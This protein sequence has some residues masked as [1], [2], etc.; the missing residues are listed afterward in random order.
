[1]FRLLF[2][3]N[4]PRALRSVCGPPEVQQARATDM[5]SAK[6]PSPFTVFA[7]LQVPMLRLLLEM[8]DLHPALQIILDRIGCTAGMLVSKDGPAVVEKK[9]NQMML[10]R[11]GPS[12]YM[13]AVLALFRLR[14]SA[15]VFSI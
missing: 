6:T 5:T 7:L 8:D 12:R 1:M 3:K 15:F 11:Q 13:K 9:F 4:P 10:D 2:F 14:Y